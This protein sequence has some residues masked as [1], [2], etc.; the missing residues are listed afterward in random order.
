MQGDALLDQR[1][2]WHCST[3]AGGPDQESG[4]SLSGHGVVQLFRVQLG[5]CL[6]VYAF[7]KVLSVATANVR[8][9]ITWT[10]LLEPCIVA[11]SE[12]HAVLLSFSLSS[13]SLSLSPSL[14]LS[15]PLSLSLFSL[16]L[17]LSLSHSHSLTLTLSLSISL[18][19]IYI[20]SSA[21]I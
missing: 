12:L 3:A 11:V 17:S 8:E 20:Y 21:Y 18:S 14:S 1:R 19:R 7:L 6:C 10:E 13:L 16:S 2:G 15:L 9:R 5:L 4:N